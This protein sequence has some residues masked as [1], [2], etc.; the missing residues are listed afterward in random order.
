M[1]RAFDRAV[2]YAAPLLAGLVAVSCG[3][4]GNTI[5][6]GGS[7]GGS[8]GGPVPAAANVVSVVVG[9]GP[10][11]T[12]INTLYTTVTVCVPGSTTA[13]QTIDNIQVD[14][15][16]Y[17][18]RLLAPVLTLS[19]V[20]ISA[21]SGTSLLECTGFVDGFSWGPIALVDVQI[22]GES[23]GS[24]PVQ[25]IGDSRFPAVPS[26]CSGIGPPENTV[27]QFGANGILGVGFLPMDCGTLCAGAAVP[28]SYYA[29]TAA[30]VCN[31]T[32]VPV[33][34]QVANPVTRF[35]TDNNGT[36]ISLSSAAA[37]GAAS[38]AG[39]LIFGIDTQSNNQSSGTQ[40]VL[41]VDAN[42][43]DPNF[44]NFTT[45]FNGQ[46]LAASFI[47]SG[48]NGYFF[49]DSSLPA[50]PGSNSEFYCPSSTQT[51]SATLQGLSGSSTSVNFTVGN[52]NN[53]TGGI[54]AYPSLAGTTPISNSFD[55][56]LP[57]FFGRKVTTA[58]SG[59]TTS[60]GTGPYV[61]F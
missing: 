3:G 34:S 35:A 29:C 21:S 51:F 24:V 42:E 55:W 57:F 41:T 13:C 39:S 1:M 19:L 33:T 9:P 22:S 50:C 45:V 8:G 23:A 20:P 11:N 4:G 15:G 14:T 17:G 40:T 12:G 16:S 54:A 58:I 28:T 61:A 26:D 49:T 46:T 18:L 43:S 32:A 53:L 47:D 56:G 10:T 27:A 36:I 59:Y 5:T 30:G 60:A 7:G 6:G 37:G 2:R 52:L 44:G 25:L 31:A 48:S 38:V